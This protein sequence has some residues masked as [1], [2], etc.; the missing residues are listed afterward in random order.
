[1]ADEG[2]QQRAVM[3]QALAEGSAV[4]ITSADFDWP[5]DE[6][7][8]PMWRI[9]VGAAELVPTVQY[10]NVTIGPC[11]ATGFVKATTPEELVAE[12]SRWQRAV[13]AAVAEERE[14]VQMLMRSRARAA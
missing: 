4:T 10:G 3:R 1:M 14:T 13:E 6:N 8:A 7:G 5:R 12:I 2:P 9:S 11:I